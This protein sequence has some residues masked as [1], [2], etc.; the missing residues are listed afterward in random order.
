MWLYEAPLNFY[1]IAS[2]QENLEPVVGPGA[3][4]PGTQVYVVNSLFDG[5]LIGEKNLQLLSATRTTHA[6][7]AVKPTL[8]EELRAGPCVQ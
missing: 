5:P 6:W 2:G 7:I 3:D 4:R 8:Y 1:R